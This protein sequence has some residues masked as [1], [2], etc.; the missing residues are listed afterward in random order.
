M[1][2]K[3]FE[4]LLNLSLSK[5]FTMKANRPGNMPPSEALRKPLLDDLDAYTDLQKKA[6]IDVAKIKD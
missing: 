1:E 5:G 6:H 3:S 4:S 2:H